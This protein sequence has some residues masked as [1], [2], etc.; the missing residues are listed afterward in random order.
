M[1]SSHKSQTSQPRLRSR[2]DGL[3]KH[4]RG[5][6]TY[7]AAVRLVSFILVALLAF[8]ASIA[9]ATF[10]DLTT[11]VHS[12]TVQ[13]ISQK[14][15]KKLPPPTPLDPN[16]GK[17][18]NLLV[19]GQDNRDGDNASLVGAYAKYDQG[20]HLADTTMVVQISADRS[21]IN[22][23]SIPRDSLV[24]APACRTSRG[25]VP[26]RYHVMFNSIF[27]TGWRVGG[28]LAS[29][30]TCAITAV[31]SLTGLDIS[32]FIVVDF[33]GLESMINSIG[34]VDLCIPVDTRDRYT[35]LN[36]TRGLHHL[37]G[38]QATQYARMRHGTGT[39]GSDIMR[40]ARQQYLIK[41][42]L[43]QSLNK[44]ILTHTAQLYQ[45]AKSAL[46]S[47][48][49]SQG[50]G[51]IST[52]TGLAFSLR[53]FDTSHLYSQTIPVVS[54][55]NNPN[56]VIWARSASKVWQK[57]REGVPLT[58]EAPT[59]TTTPQSSAASQSSFNEDL[60]QSQAQTTVANTSSTVV[61]IA[62]SSR[63]TSKNSTSHTTNTPAA[64]ATPTIDPE[65]GL[66]KNAAGQLIDPRT[67][68]IVDPRTGIIRSSVTG[69]S[70]GIA[71][72]YLRNV[73]CAPQPPSKTK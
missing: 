35:N 2:R 1:S 55:P 34:G 9:S 57:L 41:E 70:I 31:N 21:Y 6:R 40:T 62:R 60:S 38:T 37:N 13:I 48:N 19:I 58:D 65:T 36:L 7:N 20:S 32:D 12:H 63:N 25:I 30:A 33:H 64:P 45:L 24:N 54:A 5:F 71:D 11:T 56:R 61:P 69:Y 39:D 18:I 52:L 10:L 68:G 73:V 22:L 28:N 49:F 29:A 4:S 51:D 67:N 72:K 14:K 17:P 27:S 47:L 15:D 59:T 8:A 46:G 23:V 44:D 42:L 16:S 50:L 53:H 26:A 66:I 3:P 43:R